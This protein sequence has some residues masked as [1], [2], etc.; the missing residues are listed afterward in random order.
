[1]EGTN[2]HTNSTKSSKNITYDMQHIASTK[3]AVIEVYKLQ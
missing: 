1:M 2:L 3:A